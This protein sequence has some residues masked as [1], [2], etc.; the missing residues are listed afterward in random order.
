MTAEINVNCFRFFFAQVTVAARD[1]VPFFGP[2]LPNPSVFEKGSEFREFLLTKLINAEH[3]C[4]KADRFAKLEVRT[5]PKVESVI[6]SHVCLFS[7]F[8]AGRDPSYEQNH[9]H[10]E[11]HVGTNNIPKNVCRSEP[12]RRCWTHCIRIYTRITSPFMD[13]FHY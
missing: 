5:K 10:L 11:G 7:L 4:Y 1:D 8:S 13:R 3:A 9:W 6:S 12:G 2:T